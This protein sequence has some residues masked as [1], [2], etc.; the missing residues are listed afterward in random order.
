M[1][2]INEILAQIMLFL[3]QWQWLLK[4]KLAL[5]VGFFLFSLLIAIA[6]TYRAFRDKRYV[7]PRG[8]AR[9]RY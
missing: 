2:E 4:W 6:I 5:A 1:N 9:F 3:Y 7:V 8:S